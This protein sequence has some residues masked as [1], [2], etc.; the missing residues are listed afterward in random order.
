MERCEQNAEAEQNVMFKSLRLAI[1]YRIMKLHADGNRERADDRIQVEHFS[2]LFCCAPV[3]LSETNKDFINYG[4]VSK[5]NL[6][7]QQIIDCME[8]V[9]IKANNDKQTKPHYGLIQ[10]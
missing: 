1:F 10:S 2:S 9:M 7:D 8:I 3:S 5:L 4:K 6:L